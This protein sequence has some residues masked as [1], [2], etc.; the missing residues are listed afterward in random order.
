[1]PMAN[2]SKPNLFVPLLCAAVGGVIGHFAFLWIVRQGFYALA[3]PGILIGCGAGWS[4]RQR[5][6]TCA[7]ICALLAL[8]AGIVSEWRA[9]P[10][11][12]DDGFGYFIQHLQDLRPIT[13]I[14]ILLGAIFAAWFGMGRERDAASRQIA[15]G[16]TPK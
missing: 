2:A 7:I 12:K 10:F 4:L 9:H 16:D 3:L 15:T 6:G 5:S 8:V 13:I 11:I 1:M 14:M